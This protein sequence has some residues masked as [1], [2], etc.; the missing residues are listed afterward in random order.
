MNSIYY[1][2]FCVVF[3]DPCFNSVPLSYW[4]S[5]RV[6]NVSHLVSVFRGRGS[7]PLAGESGGVPAWL[8]DNAWQLALRSGL[9]SVSGLSGWW[10]L[11][12][13][14]TQ[15]TIRLC[16]KPN[17]PSIT[18]LYDCPDPRLI[19]RQRDAG[20]GGSGGMDPEDMVKKRTRH[21]DVKGALF[22]EN[23]ASSVWPSTMLW[24][25]VLLFLDQIFSNV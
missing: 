18:C 5:G 10:P 17:R 23:V 21:K 13:S 11:T 1:S 22:E 12:S 6:V 3:V 24:R 14:L 15:T 25:T 7:E 16:W 2:V 4:L 8:Q 19:T 9:F 20:L